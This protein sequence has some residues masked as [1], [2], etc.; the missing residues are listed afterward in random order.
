MESIDALVLAKLS[1]SSV[2]L[3][4]DEL[5]DALALSPAALAASLRRLDE[6][7]VWSPNGVD[8]S[9][10]LDFFEH[11]LKYLIP[12][13]A[14]DAE[15]RGIPTA[16]Y[17]APLDAMFA[18]NGS[19]WVWPSAGGRVEGRG[20]EPIHPRVVELVLDDDA[21][22]VVL[23]CADCFRVGG[24]RERTAARPLLGALLQRNATSQRRKSA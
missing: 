1:A 17:V 10:A 15:E 24:A 19:P 13:K 7:R 11:G 21:L 23:A 18:A 4:E 14:S 20:L 3:G 12:A 16:S 2:R 9:I 5:A 6:A 22:H 8:W